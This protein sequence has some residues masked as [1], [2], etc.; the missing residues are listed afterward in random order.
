MAV[1]IPSPKED[2]VILVLRLGRFLRC[3]DGQMAT[4]PADEKFRTIVGEHASFSF[5]EKGSTAETIFG[6]STA[7]NSPFS[8][9]ICAGSGAASGLP[10]ESGRLG[11]KPE[12]TQ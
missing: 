4:I 2:E 10:I 6:E 1:Q 12:L 11:S 8:N 5:V 7:A 9:W 3:E